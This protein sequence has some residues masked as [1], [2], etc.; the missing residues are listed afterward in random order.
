MTDVKVLS[1]ERLQALIV[2]TESTLKQ[3]T[4]EL[5]RREFLQQANEIGRLEKHITDAELS[6]VTIRQFLAY[7]IDD[8]K[9]KANDEKRK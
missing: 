3:L 6:L 2:D 9:E 8:L 4:V 7:L 5:E 1:T